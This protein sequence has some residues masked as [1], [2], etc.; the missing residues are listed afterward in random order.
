VTGVIGNVRV[1][2]GTN[3]RFSHSRC[4][5]L[6]D[7][8]TLLYSTTRAASAFFLTSHPCPKQFSASDATVSLDSFSKVPI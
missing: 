6:S 3:I 5:G 8:L 2:V 4:A 7:W 1:R